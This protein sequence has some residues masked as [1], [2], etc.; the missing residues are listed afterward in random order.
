MFYANGEEIR[1]YSVG[2]LV[3]S[4]EGLQWIVDGYGWRKGFTFDDQ[5]NTLLLT[6][7]NGDRLSF[8]IKSGDIVRIER[9]PKKLLMAL[10]VGTAILLLIIGLF[11]VAKR[12]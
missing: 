7:L 1:R 6:L 5:S 10:V 12:V 2:D 9:N 11:I 4:S 8:D 3:G